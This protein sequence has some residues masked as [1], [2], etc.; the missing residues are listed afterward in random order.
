MTDN[1]IEFADAFKSP[2]HYYF[3]VGAIKNSLLA[4]EVGRLIA[5]ALLNAAA[6]TRHRRTRVLLVIDE[7]QELVADGGALG[8]LLYQ[9]RSL[10]VGVILCNQNTSQ[11][12]M[13]DSDLR[14][15]I[16]A[17]TSLQAWLATHDDIGREQLRRLGG[18]RFVHLKSLSV[19]AGDKHRA[20]VTLRQEVVDRI[21]GTL[22]SEVSSDPERFF[23]RLTDNDG[24]A[25]YG[26]LIF[27]GRGMFHQTKAAYD[28]DCASAWPAENT[29]TFVNGPAPASSPPSATTVRKVGPSSRKGKTTRLGKKPS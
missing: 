14:S 24:Y 20:T 1:A 18:Q 9:A 29:Q 23:L 13:P 10:G 25:C 11:L 27:A 4:G 5:A 8:L 12:V 6:A 28:K 21:S 7:F 16:E 19:R 2:C 22:V 26:D 17:N 3:A 15:I